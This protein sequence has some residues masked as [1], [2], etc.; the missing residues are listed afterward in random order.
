MPS[1]KDV[2]IVAGLINA[3]IAAVLGAVAANVPISDSVDNFIA[4][5]HRQGTWASWAAIT[6]AISA[7]LQA[8][9]HFV[10]AS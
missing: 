2:L 5:L 3:V 1:L 6:A 9:A 7:G 8:V 4:D 10:P